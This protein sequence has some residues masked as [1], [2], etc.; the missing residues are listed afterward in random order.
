MNFLI[1]IILVAALDRLR[2]H[3]QFGRWFDNSILAKV[4]NEHLHKWLR[5]KAVDKW[6]PFGR[7]TPPQMYDLYH[8]TKG[9]IF[10]ALI[11]YHCTID[12]W[13]WFFADAILIFIT[14]LIF[15]GNDKQKEK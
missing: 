14:Q 6:K 12:G 1:V 10:L 15:E 5:S 3:T 2:E 7:Y 13:K 4:K 11:I 8:F 9:L